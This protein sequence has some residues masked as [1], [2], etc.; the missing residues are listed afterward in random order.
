MKSASARSCP[1]RLTRRLVGLVQERRAGAAWPSEATRSARPSSTRLQPSAACSRPVLPSRL[2]AFTWSS[3]P[4]SRKASAASG[5]SRTLSARSGWATIGVE[6][7]GLHVLC[8]ALSERERAVERH[9]HEHRVQVAEPIAAGI[10]VQEPL[11]GRQLPAEPQ[12]ERRAAPARP[13]S[14]RAPRGPRARARASAAATARRAASRR[15]TLVPCRPRLEAERQAASTE[16]A[17][18]SPEG[19]T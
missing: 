18:S 5:R 2:V 16:R 6:P 4:R 7:V 3:Q 1:T 9:L 19:T 14:R 10:L 17:P 15:A 11:G 13:P 12:V 8:E